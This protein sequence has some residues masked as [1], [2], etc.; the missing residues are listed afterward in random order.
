[1]TTVEVRCPEDPRRM[2]MK[3]HQ[4]PTVRIVPGNLIEV[5]C[6]SCSRVAGQRVLH[7]FD[8]TGA[9]IETTTETT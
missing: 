9:L 5:A 1:V 6:R 7:R 3:L 8:I 4:D 2:F